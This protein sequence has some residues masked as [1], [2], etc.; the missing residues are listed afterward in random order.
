MSSKIQKAD[1]I[2]S[3]IKAAGS[4]SRSPRRVLP[5]LR[6]ISKTFEEGT[7]R[8]QQQHPDILEIL[9]TENQL[10][11]RIDELGRYAFCLVVL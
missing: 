10:K 1:G 3:R 11:T 4:I 6:T 7:A 8:Q 5:P 9:F 2:L